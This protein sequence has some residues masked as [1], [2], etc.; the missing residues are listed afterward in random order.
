MV[1]GAAL[2]LPTPFAS[3]LRNDK[4]ESSGLLLPEIK[5]GSRGRYLQ[6]TP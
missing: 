1:T 4:S 5:Y 3:R 6:S 2:S